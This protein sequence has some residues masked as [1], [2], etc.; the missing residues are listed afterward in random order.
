VTLERTDDKTIATPGWRSFRICSVTADN[1]WTEHCSGLIDVEGETATSK[2]MAWQG[3]LS[4]VRFARHGQDAEYWKI[5]DPEDLYAAIRATGIDHGPIFQNI[6]TVNH[7]KNPQSRSPIL[8]PRCRAAMRMPISSTLPPLTRYSR[9][10]TV[11][12][13][14]RLRPHCV[15][16]INYLLI[17]LLSAQPFNCSSLSSCTRSIMALYICS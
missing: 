11:P 13:W 4:D 15:Y 6:Q 14:R 8:P 3:P 9:H 16:F 1:E 2:T 17:C 10:P 5:M 7:R 12:T